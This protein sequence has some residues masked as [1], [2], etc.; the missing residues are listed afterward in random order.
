MIPILKSVQRW[1]SARRRRRFF[2]SYQAMISDIAL[3]RQADA[4]RE[5]AHYVETHMAAVQSVA[6]WRAVHD[7]AIGQVKIPGGLCLEFG[8]YS[9]TSINHI[10]AARDWTVIG[11]DSFEGLPEN[12]RD[13]YP[14]GTFHRAEPPTVASNVELNVGWFAETLPDFKSSLVPDDHPIAYLHIDSDLYSSAVTV[15]DELGDN[16]TAGTVIV[17]DEYFN[18]PG[19]QEG[20]F[21]AFQEFVAMRNLRYRYL[22]YNRTHQQVA[23]QITESP[24]RFQKD[25]P[26]PD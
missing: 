26:N 17:F 11:F 4:T 25:A 18:Y 2:T 6:S 12:W 20:G 16:I 22:V 19:W 15:F 3:A 8:V 21:R 7:V 23:L 5:T 24:T 13:G 14:K 10:A 9:G 1:I